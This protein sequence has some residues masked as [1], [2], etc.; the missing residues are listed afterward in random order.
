MNPAREP[1]GRKCVT[2]HSMRWQ[3]QGTLSL[4]SRDHHG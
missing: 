2:E 4:L 3:P 1:C